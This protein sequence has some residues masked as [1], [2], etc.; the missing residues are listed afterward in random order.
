MHL[1]HDALVSF[2]ERRVID[3]KKFFTFKTLRKKYKDLILLMI[4]VLI[5]QWFSGFFTGS[6][7]MTIFCHNA[8]LVLAFIL[9]T[10][11]AD[12]INLKKE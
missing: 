5:C 8:V 9:G 1:F 7:I 3:M 6:S 11:L 2:A 10:L 4:I 12:W